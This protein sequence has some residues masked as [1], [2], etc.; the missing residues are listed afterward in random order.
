MQ[1]FVPNQI[2]PIKVK[3]VNQKGLKKCEE[4]SE[5]F[6]L[7]TWKFFS[8]NTSI[9]GVHYLMEAS[10]SL[11]E[12]V[13]WAIFIIVASVGMSY[14]CIMLSERFQNSKTSTVFESTNFKVSEIPFPAV[15]L[16]SNNRLNLTKTNETIAKFLGNSSEG[17]TMKKIL[18]LMQNM[19]WGSFDEFV[20]IE[21]DTI[22]AIDKLNLTEVHEY[23]M[24]DCEQFFVSCSWRKVAFNC[25]EWFS[26]Q[27]T[28]YGL[29]WSFN[30]FSNVGSVFIN[31]SFAV[32]KKKLFN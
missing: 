18:T 14:T 24:H 26:K 23:I 20:E 9:H 8:R 27:K 13:M 5:N 32:S 25:C 3:S 16:C 11:L 4:K 12:K 28:E 30:S 6:V 15:T 19:E 7:S 29:C 1:L 31:V 10:I 22:D 2:Q 21:N 17:E